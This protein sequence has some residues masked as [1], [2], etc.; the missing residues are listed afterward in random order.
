[1][2]KKGDIN[3]HHLDNYTGIQFLAKRVTDKYLTP[4]E[5]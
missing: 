1:M 2:F 3:K 5:S 4:Y